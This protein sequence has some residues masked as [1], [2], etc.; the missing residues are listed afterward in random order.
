[1][2]C[3]ATTKRANAHQYHPFAWLWVIKPLQ[4]AQKRVHSS[5]CERIFALNV[6]QLC[7]ASRDSCETALAD[8][9]S[10]LR[11]ASPPL[12][13]VTGRHEVWRLRWSL[14]AICRNMKVT[15]D[16]ARVVSSLQALVSVQYVVKVVMLGRAVVFASK[17]AV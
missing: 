15:L 16:V 3:Y 1:M 14:E 12:D 10:C 2:Q 13:L 17:Q 4:D 7:G 11:H 8:P 9:S 6:R 5:G